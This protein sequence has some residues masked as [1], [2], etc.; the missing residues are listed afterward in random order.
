MTIL[1][2]A[3]GLASTVFAPIVAGTPDGARLARDLPRPRDHARRPHLAVALVLP[4]A[5]LGAAAA[6][7]PRRAGAPRL[8]SGSNPAVLGARVLDGLARH[9][10]VQR[11]PRRH[12]AVHGEGPHV[13]ARGMGARAA[14]RRPGHRS[15]RLRGAPASECAVGAARRDV[16]ARGR[17]PGADGAR[18]RSAVAAHRDRDGG[19]SGPWSPDARARVGCRRSMGNAELRVASTAC[20]RRRS[21]RSPHSAPRLGPLSRLAS[22]VMQPW[23][24]SWPASPSS[25]S[26]RRDSRSGEPVRRP[27]RAWCMRRVQQSGSSPSFRTQADGTT[28]PE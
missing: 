13:R 10:A 17:A 6:A 28:S 22:E 19:G 12:P 1:T 9:R 26:S 14:R 15:T 27:R 7:A 21:P 16:R 3:G 2:L 5:Q 11:D 23:R 25:Q 18:A 24:S 20:S 8:V 4:R